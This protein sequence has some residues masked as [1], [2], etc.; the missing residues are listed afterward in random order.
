MRQFGRE[1]KIPFIVLDVPLDFHLAHKGE[2]SSKIMSLYGKGH[3]RAPQPITV[4]GA[5]KM[6]QAL[7]TMQSRKH[8]GKLV[9]TSRP[10]RS[11]KSSLSRRIHDSYEEMHPYLF[12]RGLGGIGRATAF[13]LLKCGAINLIFASPSGS[14]KT[15]P[16]EAIAQFKRQGARVAVFSCD[17]SN[18]ADLDQALEQSKREMTPIRGVIHGTMVLKVG[19]LFNVYA[20]QTSDECRWICLRI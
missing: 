17:I 10:D 13:W 12:I 2:I 5:S 8:L 20:F 7:R 11:F 18:I 6:E 4:Y 3:L 19:K 1:K 9:L 16:K 15:K 14:A